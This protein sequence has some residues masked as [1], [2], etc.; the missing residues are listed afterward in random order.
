MTRPDSGTMMVET[1]IAAGIV[2]IML[3]AMYGSIAESASRQRMVDARRQALMVARSEL[4][5][6]GAEVPATPGHT[7]GITGNY[8]WQ[9]DVVPYSGDLN[10]SYAGPL[11]EVSVAVRRNGEG[12][13]PLATLRTLRVMPSVTGHG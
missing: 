2:A 11:G 6:V 7:T 13:A 5:L 4:A 10:P 3:G 9:I 8:A 1:L 12:G